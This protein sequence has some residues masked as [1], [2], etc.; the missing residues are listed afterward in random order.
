MC[1]A[2]VRFVPNFIML[3]IFIPKKCNPP[4]FRMN[5][6]CMNTVVTVKGILADGTT[7]TDYESWKLFNSAQPQGSGGLVGGGTPWQKIN[8][9]AT[10]A[11][12]VITAGPDKPKPYSANGGLAELGGDAVMAILTMSPTEVG[13]LFCFVFFCLQS[14]AKARDR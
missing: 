9:D 6:D 1:V 2:W 10:T 13:L 12:G 5:S 4:H 3:F 8:W 14:S 7:G 11:G